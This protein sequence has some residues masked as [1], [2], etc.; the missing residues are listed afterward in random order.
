MTF[1]DFAIMKFLDAARIGDPA[2]KVLE[3]PSR[4]ASSLVFPLYGKIRF[5]ERNG[6]VSYADARHPLYLPR[7]AAYR[8]ECVEA[9][10]SLM[11]TFYDNQ[12]ETAIRALPPVDLDEVK[13]VYGSLQNIQT[14][15][16]DAAR[17]AAIGCLYRLLAAVTEEQHRKPELFR[18]AV[19]L[20]SLHLDDPAFTV[21]QTAA[22]LFISEV[23]LRKLFRKTAGVSPSQYLIRLRMERAAMYLRENRNV[24]ETAE[25][26]GYASVYS[27]SRAF[28]DRFG[29]SPAF[30]RK[31][32]DGRD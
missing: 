19:S 5:T 6:T 25:A 27:F 16:G 13:N 12:T 8:N 1:S 20:M 18:R 15:E 26:V 32:K 31:S 21:R 23:Y 14:Q 24:T 9:A 10:E 2:G 4:Y 22:E 30:F 11:F 28:R 3:M 29:I 7:G 17:F